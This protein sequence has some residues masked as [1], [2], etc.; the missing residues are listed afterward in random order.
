[1]INQILDDINSDINT[2]VAST[3]IDEITKNLVE[4]IPLSQFDDL[5]ITLPE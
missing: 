3:Q 2:E 4:R 1:M 5:K